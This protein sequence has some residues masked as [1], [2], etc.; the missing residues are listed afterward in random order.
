M[1]NMSKRAQEHFA[2]GFNCAESVFLAALEETEGLDKDIVRVASAFGGGLGQK[3]V[4][5]AVAGAA[6]AIGV[7]FGRTKFNDDRTPSQ[8]AVMK[9]MINF[10]KNYKTVKCG[11]LTEGYD[12]SS[13]ERK[14]YCSEIVAQAAQELEKILVG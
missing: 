3:E 10:K 8:L 6:M 2:S 4:C 5:G 7:K 14:D 11:E 1:T 12:M 9:L 13:K